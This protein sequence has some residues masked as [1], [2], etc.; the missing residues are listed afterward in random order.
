[1]RREVTG[2]LSHSE[3]NGHNLPECILTHFSKGKTKGNKELDL[4]L[5][6]RRLPQKAVIQR[7]TQN[8]HRTSLT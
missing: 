4:Y 7:T 5:Q 3:T 6:R 8:H 1:M 2:Y